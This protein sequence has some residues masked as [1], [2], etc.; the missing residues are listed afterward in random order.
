MRDLERY[1]AVPQLLVDAIDTFS[2]R[3]NEA[4]DRRTAHTASF[5]LGEAEVVIEREELAPPGIAFGARQLLILEAGAI[6]GLDSV[7]VLRMIGL[8]RIQ[9]ALGLVEC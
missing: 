9:R 1:L 4:S 6:H 3:P 7:A 8:G 5:I 2:D